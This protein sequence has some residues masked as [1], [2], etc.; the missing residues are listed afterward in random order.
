MKL[1]TKEIITK[2][3][4]RGV[5]KN[6]QDDDPI[7]CKFFNPVGQGTWYVMDGEKQE[8]GDWFFF[9]F[10]EWMEKEWGSFSLNE[11]ESAKLPFGLGIERD[12][13]YRGT[14]LDLKNLA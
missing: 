11:L 12:R 7:I 10:V 14:Y 6:Y 3:E 5:G 2:L 4:K 9:G 8:N 1:L 13:N